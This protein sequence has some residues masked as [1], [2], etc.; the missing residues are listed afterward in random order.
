MADNHRSGAAIFFS[1]AREDER[2]VRELYARMRQRG[3][4]P[5]LDEENLVPARAWEPQI[6][7][8]LNAARCVVIFFSN[9]MLEKRGYIRNEVAAAVEAARSRPPGYLIPVRLDDCTLPGDVADFTQVDARIGDGPGVLEGR[10][11]SA[12]DLFTDPRD[13]EVYR[14]RTIGA[15]TWLADDFR[16]LVDRSYETTGLDPAISSPGRL[17]TW[18]AAVRA[19]PHGWRLPSDGDWRRLALDAGGL[20]DMDDGYPHEG[21]Q[22]GDASAAFRSLTAGGDSGF[23]VRLVGFRSSSG[24]LSRV[25]SIAV[26]WTSSVIN[27]DVT[28]SSFIGRKIEAPW[29][30]IFYT[31]SPRPELRRDWSI[32]ADFPEEFD[33]DPKNCAVSVRYVTDDAQ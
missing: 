19:C 14:T 15:C 9:R 30:Y 23:G 4:A 12:L 8:A 18:E 28:T 3:L 22:I 11:K 24:T 33:L 20:R 32:P 21:R 17:Y 29:V 10:I 6:I 25:G 16:Y 1:Y 5:W 13:G 26:F 2:Q 31:I 27:V 7:Q